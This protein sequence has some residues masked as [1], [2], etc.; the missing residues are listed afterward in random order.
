MSC[1]TPA[2]RRLVLAATGALLLPRAV[3]AQRAKR[4]RIAFLNLGS[5]ASAEAYFGVLQQGL[6]ALGYLDEDI[7]IEIRGANGHLERLSDLAAELVHLG[8][9]VIIGLGP[10]VVQALRQA[11][12]TIPIVMVDVA[13]P[14]GLGFVASLAHPAANV[15]GLANL[16]QETVGKRLQLLKTAIPD[17][18]RIAML[19][20]PG[21]RGNILQLEATREAAGTLRIELLP[22]ETRAAGEIE[23]AFALMARGRAEALIVASDPVFFLEKTRIV[24]LAARQKLPAIYQLREYSTIGGLMSLGPDLNDL[25]G[26]AASFVDKILKGAKPADLPVEQPTKFELVVNLKAAQALGLTIPPSIL[27]GADEVI[28]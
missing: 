26:R 4:R 17:A 21:N 13:D 7:E 22:V 19:V 6:H 9:E 3:D 18:E 25:W 12:P 10:A 23:S 1:G 16:A 14:V 8:P 5:R 24:D 15:T 27:A 2:T 28:E 11:A 20:N